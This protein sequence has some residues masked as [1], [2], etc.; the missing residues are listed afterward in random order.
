MS[1]RRVV[2]LLLPLLVLLLT[3]MGCR[4]GEPKE[5][6]QLEFTALT[7]DAAPAEVK[8]YYEEMRAVPGFFVL[9]REGEA[10]L[11]L[12][13][14]SVDEP[15]QSLT[16]TDLRHV[17]GDWRLLARLESGEGAAAYPYAVVR[18][19]APLE[20]RFTARLVQLSGEVLEL[21]GM[22]VSDR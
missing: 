17:E 13:A 8:Q 15:G 20:A 9:H 5:G 1:G 18:V 21:Q 19:K 16:I 11:L 3:L 4:S 6:N 10:Y 22:L 7:L 12:M 2:R 14:G